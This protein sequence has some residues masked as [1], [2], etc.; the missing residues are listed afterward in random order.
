MYLDPVY[1]PGGKPVI[2][3]PPVPIS[4]R[5][6]VGPVLVIVARPRAPYVDAVPK[7]MVAYSCQKYGPRNNLGEIRT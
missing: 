4:P 1:T 3:V 6:S 7:V 2:D 5:I